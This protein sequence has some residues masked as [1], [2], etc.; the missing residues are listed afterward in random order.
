MSDD[1]KFDIVGKIQKKRK[2][3]GFRKKIESQRA[4]RGDK[5]SF[6]Q[7]NEFVHELQRDAHKK[8]WD[9]GYKI[10]FNDRKVKFRIQGALT[11]ALTTLVGICPVLWFLFQ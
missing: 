8:G 2:A 1:D 6:N 11:G 4:E 3:A 5:V 10:G 9:E 7:L